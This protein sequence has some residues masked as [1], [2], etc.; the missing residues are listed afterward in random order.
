MKNERR[1]TDA[2]NPIIKNLID[3]YPRLKEQEKMHDL[4]RSILEEKFTQTKAET[5]THQGMLFHYKKHTHWS[6]RD[7]IYEILEEECKLPLA[8]SI[9]KAIEK[10][11]ELDEFLLPSESSSVRLSAGRMNKI[12]AEIE[13]KRIKELE[14]IMRQHSFEHLAS[15][16]ISNK[17]D[18]TVSEQ[19]YE[20]LKKQLYSHMVE[21]KITEMP[22]G[23]GTF[24]I[25]DE[26]Q[27]HDVEKI[28]FEEIVKKQALL[29]LQ[30]EDGIHMLNLFTGEIQILDEQTPYEGHLFW[31]ENEDLFCD[32]TLLS[33]PGFA[34]EYRADIALTMQLWLS[35]GAKFH[36]GK[37][38]V[39]GMH[40]FRH[41]PISSV[42]L[43]ELLD[44]DLIQQKLIDSN[45]YCAKE[46]D[47]NLRFEAIDE[48][49]FTDRKNM[50]YNKLIK[51]SQA[52]L[53]R[54]EEEI[55]VFVS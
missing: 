41:C 51:R 33:G 5:I 36:Y 10:R 11:F 44:R 17:L 32:D 24:K 47:L 55:D 9:P 12:Q 38:M 50:F 19:K 2:M 23:V 43:D 52:L 35:Q 48:S 40:F 54:Q 26:K 13:K 6:W 20:R 25:V 22:S 28:A 14:N 53:K 49:S 4:Y 29:T 42:K 18:L 7:S 16:F 34:M 3:L 30:K 15:L 45:R 27:Y 8:V 1:Q 31:Y 21:N 37:M 46:E 39:E